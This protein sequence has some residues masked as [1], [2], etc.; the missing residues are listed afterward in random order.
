MLLALLLRRILT[1]GGSGCP[2]EDL[3]RES[4]PLKICR[5]GALQI[6]SLSTVVSSHQGTTTRLHAWCLVA[7]GV[8][9]RREGRGG[10][11]LPADSP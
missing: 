1:H 11:V 7:R 9:P 8:I 10:M 6:D 4:C 5:Q 2:H 3:L